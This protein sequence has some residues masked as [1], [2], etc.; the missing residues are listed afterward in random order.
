MP[1]DVRFCRSCGASVGPP[2]RAPESEPASPGLTP[3][4]APPV[5]QS[6]APPVGEPLPAPPVAPPVDP[7]T[8]APPAPPVGWL[9]GDPGS[10]GGPGG[11]GG[12]G[13]PGAPG[14]KGRRGLWIALAAV[15]VVVIAA[16]ITVPLVLARGGNDEVA[17]TS[18]APTTS[19]TT[20]PVNTT[21]PTTS[22]TSTSATTATTATTE[23]GRPGD[24]AGEWV[25]TD[26][27]GAPAQVM[28]VAVSDD[29]L[30]MGAQTDSGYGLY[31]YT[32]LTDTMVELPVEGTDLGGIDIDDDIAAWAEAT[33]DEA[34]SSYIDQHI[35]TYALP[36]GPKVDVAGATKS[37]SYPQRAGMWVTWVEP[38]TWDANPEEYL[39]VPIYGSFVSLGSETANDP[40]QLVP[41]AVAPVMGDATWTYSLGKTFLAWEQ[42]T[43]VGDLD[44]GTYVL[45][46]M[47]VPAEPRLI[48]KEAWRPSVYLDN[49]VYMENG[50]QFLNLATGEKSEIDPKGDFPTT[51]SSFAAYYRAVES[52]D[53]S[54]YEIVARGLTG[55]Y[56]QVLAQQADAPWLSPPIAASGNHV[57]FVADG[58]LHVFEWK[59]Q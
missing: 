13:G 45:D 54:T 32:F 16:A 38:S 14:A 30:L 25:E 55:G 1:D 26:I 33:Y 18:T 42:A 8:F 53:G 27:P 35:Y 43:A 7:R 58:I 56:E 17:V 49:L 4:P 22:S 41:S 29:V 3:P 6:V 9:P 2:E 20:K 37:V 5:S 21:A 23:A 50:L 51:A 40:M 39:R 59:G 19:T 57:A 12:P 52:G 44:A 28:A 48:G 11:I 31:A 47:T 10:P 15:A 34:S 46:L 36:D 24:S